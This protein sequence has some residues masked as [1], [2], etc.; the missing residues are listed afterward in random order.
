MEHDIYNVV[1]FLGHAT[2][3]FST[4]YLCRGSVLQKQRD[5]GQISFSVYRCE[6]E[7]LQDVYI[8]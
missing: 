6:T 8:K 1:N 7:T 3:L 5:T 4:W 2:V